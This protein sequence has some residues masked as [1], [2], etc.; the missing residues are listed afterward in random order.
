MSSHCYQCT[1]VHC[2]R[3]IHEDLGVPFLA[4]HFRF[5]T[6]RS[7]SKSVDVGNPLV[8]QLSWYLRW[9]NVDPGLVKRPTGDQ[10]RQSFRDYLPKG[11]HVDTMNRAQLELS[12]T[13]TEFYCVLFSL[14]V[15]WMPGYNTQRR[16][17]VRTLPSMVALP[18]CLNFLASLTLDT[19]NLGSNPRKLSS[20]S[21]TPSYRPIA[22]WATVLSLSTKK[23]ST[24]AGNSLP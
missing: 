20:R 9:R 7:D 13:L 18:K 23:P 14:V 22:S 19:I 15:R 11:G 17:A 16:G 24:A 12:T 4:D 5:L 8:M 3:Q 1:L 21:Y 2:N 10:N 6:E